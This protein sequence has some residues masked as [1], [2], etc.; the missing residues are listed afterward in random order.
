MNKSSTNICNATEMHTS[1]LCSSCLREVSLRAKRLEGP[2]KVLLHMLDVMHQWNF[3]ISNSGQMTIHTP[4]NHILDDH[5][6]HR[7]TKISILKA[8]VVDYIASTV[9][10]WSNVVLGVSSHDSENCCNRNIDMHTL[11]YISTHNKTL[12]YMYPGVSHEGH[13]EYW[14]VLCNVQWWLQVL[15]SCKW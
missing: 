3:N 13:L 10:I 6:V 5:I 15:S 8:T 12:S 1:Y 2:F 4:A 11:C 14:I 7:F 9:Q